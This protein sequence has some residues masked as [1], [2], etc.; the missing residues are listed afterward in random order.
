MILIQILTDRKLE[1]A[2]I[3]LDY[4][5]VHV[6][7]LEEGN[8]EA[9]AYGWNISY[10]FDNG[11]LNKISVERN[12][13]YKYPEICIVIVIIFPIA[14]ILFLIWLISKNRK[15]ENKNT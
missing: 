5:D 9:S 8:L 4:D 14:V 3:A 7:I 6:E 2:N 1:K 13:S 10:N 15:F 11:K 12:F